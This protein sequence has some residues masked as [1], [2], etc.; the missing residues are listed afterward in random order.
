MDMD[1]LTRQLDRSIEQRF[2][3]PVEVID[4]EIGYAEP[5]TIDGDG[6]TTIKKN[7]SAYT[8][9][10]RKEHDRER[11]AYAA[12]TMG[13]ER[14]I[15]HVFRK[16]KTAKELK[17]AM[18]QRFGGNGKSK[19]M[20]QPQKL[21]M[22]SGQHVKNLSAEDVNVIDHALMAEINSQTK[23]EVDSNLFTFR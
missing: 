3:K 5:T 18:G 8:K 7:A 1:D 2:E 17:D 9:E 6:C 20:S 4:L 14:E 16:Y 21:E 23:V 22:G 13:F 12:I 19:K 10:E 11:K 15:H